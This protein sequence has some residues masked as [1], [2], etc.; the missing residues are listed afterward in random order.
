[1][2]GRE[3]KIERKRCKGKKGKSFC[4]DLILINSLN[5]CRP[6]VRRPGDRGC[7]FVYLYEVSFHLDYWWISSSLYF[8][9]SSNSFY[10][11]KT[12][13]F[14]KIAWDRLCAFSC[15]PDLTLDFLCMV[16]EEEKKQKNKQKTILYVVLFILGNT[17]HCHLLK[18]SNLFILNNLRVEINIKKTTFCSTQIKP[19]GLHFLP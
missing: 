2:R 4:V 8:C 19:R 16:I 12:H 10:E 15:I 5:V 18:H 6:G 11:A 7:V 1:M 17:S 3:R 13:R 9:L 14:D